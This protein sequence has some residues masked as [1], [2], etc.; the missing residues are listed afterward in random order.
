MLL[1]LFKEFVLSEE[2]K[3]PELLKNFDNIFEI[4]LPLEMA[5]MAYDT[6][7]RQKKTFKPQPN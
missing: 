6:E 5:P 3:R 2:R 4:G 7:V 1:C